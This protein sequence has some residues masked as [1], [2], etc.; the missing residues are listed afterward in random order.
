MTLA[1]RKVPYSWL[2]YSSLFSSI[3]NWKATFK[4]AFDLFTQWDK[5]MQPII[6][7]KPIE[8][9]PGSKVS[10]TFF[11]NLLSL[12]TSSLAELLIPKSTNHEVGTG[13]KLTGA[14]IYYLMDPNCFWKSWSHT[15]CT[16]TF[17]WLSLECPTA[18]SF[19]I[20][21]W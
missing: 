16:S 4:F 20:P 21:T 2:M 6:Y 7:S 17:W 12:T 3:N 15:C 10:R 1:A 9:P 14:P 5:I 19:L 11:I 13:A 8:L 18:K